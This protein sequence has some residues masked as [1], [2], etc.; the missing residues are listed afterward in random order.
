MT[1]DLVE[2]ESKRGEFVWIAIALV[3]AAAFVLLALSMVFSKG[4]CCADDANNAVAA[5]N[6]A[7]G[8]GYTTTMSQLPDRFR[9]ES[10]EVHV[11][12]GPTLVL[13]AAVL[14]RLFGNTYWAPGLSTVL[15]WTVVLVLIGLLARKYNPGPG[16]TLAV[17]TF[18]FLCYGLMTLHFEQWYALLGEIPAALSLLLGVLLFYHSEA[19]LIRFLAGLVMGLAVLAKLSALIGIGVFILVLLLR[20]R[21]GRRR[22]MPV[23]SRELIGALAAVAVGFILPILLFEVWKFIVLGAAGYAANFSASWNYIHAQAGESHPGKTLLALYS[24]GVT[25]LLTRFHILLPD[26]VFV[27]AVVWLIVRDDAKLRQ[28][29]VALACMIVVYSAWWLF[30]SIGWPRYFI[31]ALPI[32]VFVV[33][34]PFLR[35]SSGWRIHLPYALLL[36]AWSSFSWSSLAQPIS[37]LQGS[38]FTPSAQTQ[39]LLKVKDILEPVAERNGTIITQWWATG[40]DIEYIL[41]THHSITHEMDLDSIGKHRYWIAVNTKWMGENDQ[42]LTTLLAA[43]P[44]VR[45]IDVYLVARCDSSGS[46]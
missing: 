34:L 28:L 45:M 10:F 38:W 31:I 5:K 22:L 43:C 18:L 4:V 7:T 46:P 23:V 33:A 11:T 37:E 32:I 3:A 29:Y 19:R 39:A 13:P 6:L 20:D 41:D 30:A 17:L 24:D 8:L 35:R 26:L 1:R 15:Y 42:R 25:A 16:F 27:L 44:N 14:I 21:I 36:L 40:I 12:T 9:V 2:T